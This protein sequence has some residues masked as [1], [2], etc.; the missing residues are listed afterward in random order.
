MKK[1]NIR[2]NDF[3]LRKKKD[4][5]F[6]SDITDQDHHDEFADGPSKFVKTIS[7]KKWK[8]FNLFNEG[9]LPNKPSTTGLTL[10]QHA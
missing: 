9:I 5:Y 10:I 8:T 7:K 6:L 2:I 1:T 3:F 4:Q